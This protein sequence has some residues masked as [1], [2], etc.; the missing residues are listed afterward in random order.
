MPVPQ[1]RGVGW[2]RAAVK[3]DLGD[4]PD[5]TPKY[6]P[7]QQKPLMIPDTLMRRA[8]SLERDARGG[9][10]RLDAEEERGERVNISYTYYQTEL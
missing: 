6:T 1:V 8:R 7:F 10:K 2:Q 3:W 9:E 5:V 4:S